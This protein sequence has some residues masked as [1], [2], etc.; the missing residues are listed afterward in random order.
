MNLL[1]PISKIF[2]VMYLIKEHRDEHT[3]YITVML[4]DKAHKYSDLYY[5]LLG[6]GYSVVPKKVYSKY[7]VNPLYECNQT[8]EIKT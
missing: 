7:Q 2:P 1:T 6:Q 3:T 5:E 8:R 4:T